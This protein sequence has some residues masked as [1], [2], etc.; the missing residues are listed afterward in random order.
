MAA[1]TFVVWNADTS[2]ATG[3]PTT[4]ATSATSGTVKTI[5]QLKPGAGKIRVVEWG[6]GFD[7]APG[8]PMRVELVETGTIFATVTTIGS[9]ITRYNDV[10]GAAS[11]A[12][13]GVNATGFNATVEGSV[14]ASR[15][16]GFNYENGIYFKQQFPLGREPEVN[17]VSALRIRAT[18][19]TSVAQNI[20]CYIVWEE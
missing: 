11:Q 4:T 14:V 17:A 10:S 19:T 18:P 15:L 6:Y 7:A 5:L 9:G 20:W 13:A 1:P 2:A 3:P 16:L 12:T 8:A